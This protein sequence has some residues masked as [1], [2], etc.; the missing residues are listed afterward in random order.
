MVPTPLNPCPW[1]A[2][3]SSMRGTQLWNG[4]AAPPAGH[5]A[6]HTAPL[7]GTRAVTPRACPRTPVSQDSARPQSRGNKQATAGVTEGSTS[8]SLISWSHSHTLP[9]DQGPA[10][11]RQPT[12]TRPLGG[13]PAWDSG[14]LARHTGL[15]TQ[16]GQSLVSGCVVTVFNVNHV[17][18]GPLAF[19]L[20][21]ALHFT[22]WS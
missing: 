15:H 22:S 3:W 8:S 18:Q 14:G 17:E 9:G 2:A 4:A 20:H 16:K 5:S 6:P 19:T 21:G 1:A 12:A 10:Q 11:G 7:A 13:N